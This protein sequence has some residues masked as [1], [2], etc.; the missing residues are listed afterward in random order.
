MKYLVFRL[1]GPMASW[2][3]VAIGEARHSSSYPGK[4][5]IAGLLGAALGIRRE[6]EDA[7]SALVQEYHQ[8][9][10]VV[11]SG[12]IMK[13]YHTAQAPDS[14]GKFR[15]RT[16]RDEMVTGR[17]RLGTVLSSREYYTD[18]QA[19]V[20]LKISEDARWSGEQLMQALNKP[21][22]HLYLGR[23]SCPLAAPLAPQ[24][25]EAD[26]FRDALDCYELKPV[27]CGAPGEDLPDW[28]S[29]QRWLKPDAVSRYYWEGSISDFSCEDDRFSE[30]QVQKLIRTDKPLSRVRWQFSQREEYFWTCDVQP[31]N[32]VSGG[33]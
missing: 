28:M 31:E 11:S 1:Y 20:A 10:R 14:A 23:K 12:K 2:G 13:D 4:S 8:A 18:A 33:M 19:V 29:D 32:A 30:R 15:Y 22:F 3:E 9:V 25:T 27:L 5:A 16:R 26:N 17:D 24:L 21:V 7:H 6:D